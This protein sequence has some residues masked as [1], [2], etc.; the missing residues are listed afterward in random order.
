VAELEEAELG[1]DLDVGVGGG[2]IDAKEVRVQVVNADGVAVEIGLGVLPGV[3]KGEAVKDVGQAVVLE[4][5]GSNGLAQAGLEGVEVSLCPGLKLG[6]S[7]VA[8]GG[9]EGNPDTGDF[10]EGQ[11]TLP[12]VP[13]GEVAV[14]DL[15]HLQAL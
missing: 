14:E 8:L 9:D 15:G 1:E 10:A 12:A 7:M 3:V 13:G 5:E 6:Q 11:L 4:V 2:R